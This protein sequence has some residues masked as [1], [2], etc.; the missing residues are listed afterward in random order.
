L[1]FVDG[2]IVT[3]IICGFYIVTSIL[4]AIY[5]FYTAPKVL[6]FITDRGMENKKLKDKTTLIFAS[7]VV[8]IFWC[9]PPILLLFSWRGN[10][11]YWNLTFFAWFVLLGGIS[12]C[13]V[14]VFQPALSDKKKK[15]DTQKTQEGEGNSQT[16]DT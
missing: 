12:L 15:V 4:L 6:K 3:F 14:L 7:G 10:P 1:E 5:V 16:I 11:Y 2:V 9:I 8:S 13:Q